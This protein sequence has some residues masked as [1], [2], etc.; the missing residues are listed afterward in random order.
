MAKTTPIPRADLK[1]IA[2][3]RIM[4]AECLFSGGRYDGA[5]YL[6]GYAV[7]LALKAR[8]C[9]TLK[10]P[11]FDPS[12]PL[13]AFKTH[14]SGHDRCRHRT[15]EGSM[16]AFVRKLQEVEHEIA[17]ERGGVVLVA[18][19]QREDSFG[20]WDVIFSANWIKRSE[21]QGPA[22]DYILGKLQPRLTQ[23]ER[24]DLSKL[25]L[26]EPTEQFVG[27]V[28]ELLQEW[29]NPRQLMNVN[30]NGMLM[31]TAYFITADL[32]YAPLP[33]GADV[34]DLGQETAA[35]LDAMHPDAARS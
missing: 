34:A 15:A 24:M 30:I 33:M 12:G 22:F 14:S 25:L 26:F 8:I 20:K 21:S 18:L 31:T 10:W 3:A 29:G 23:R 16:N 19:F 9:R 2:R 13:Q 11:E 1:K 27:V 7:E 28:L 6:C 32:R 17:A 4:D 35:I 5:V